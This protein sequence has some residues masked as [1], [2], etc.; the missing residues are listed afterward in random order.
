MQYGAAMHR[1]LRTYFESVRLER[2]LADEELIDLLRSDLAQAVIDDPYQRELYEQQGLQQLR[3]FLAALRQAPSPKVLHTEEHFEVRVGKAVVAGRIDRIDDLG[4]GRVAIVD[5]KTGKPRAQEDADDSLQLSVYA[6]AARE[7]W[8]YQA[9][10]LA[11]YNLEE[12]QSVT[13]TRGKF[14]LEAAKAKVEDVAD[15]IDAGQ[16]D[17]KPGYHCRFCPYRSLCPATEKPLPTASTAKKAA[18]H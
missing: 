1:V 8:G 7:K 5:Y 18:I 15:R 14:Q 17:P 6:I 11:F 9:E 3:D 13:T 16:F 10:R 2:P 4:D 12:N